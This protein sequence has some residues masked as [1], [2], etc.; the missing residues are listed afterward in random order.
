MG[1]TVFLKCFSKCLSKWPKFRNIFK[2]RV[3]FC[4][5]YNYFLSI[6]FPNFED[7]VGRGGDIY[8]QSLYRES[9]TKLDRSWISQALLWLF[10][11]WVYMFPPFQPNPRNFEIELTRN[12]YLNL[13]FNNFRDYFSILSYLRIF[14][15]SSGLVMIIWF[16][17]HTL[18]FSICSHVFILQFKLCMITWKCNRED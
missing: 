1:I 7:S 9:N 18:Y 16:W 12:N 10:F 5:W 14:T 11:F 2:K 6:L 8:T 13:K 3:K 4:Y 15:L 17:I